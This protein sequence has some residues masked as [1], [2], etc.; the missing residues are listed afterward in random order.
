M[1]LSI[2][3]GPMIYGCWML[4]YAGVGRVLQM[5]GPWTLASGATQ[6]TAFATHIT[7]AFAALDTQT[8]FL[9]S[10]QIYFRECRSEGVS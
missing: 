5:A 6:L 3:H 7:A 1:R 4:P 8:P 9:F 10:S 2:R